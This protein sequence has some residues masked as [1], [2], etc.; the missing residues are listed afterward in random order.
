MTLGLPP[1][2]SYYCDSSP[3]IIILL[4]VF[5]YYTMLPW[6]FIRNNCVIVI[7]EDIGRWLWAEMNM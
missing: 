1:I 4:Y 3:E 7:P 2:L 6:W 5:A